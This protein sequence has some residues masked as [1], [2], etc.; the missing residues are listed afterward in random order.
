MF[1]VSTIILARLEENLVLMP[2]PPDTKS[3]LTCGTTLAGR[4]DKK[5]CDDYCR[6]MYNN[7]VYNSNRGASTIR[8]I[9]SILRKNRRILE[10]LLPPEEEGAKVMKQQLKGKG[11]KFSYHTSAYAHANGAVYYFCYE[12]GY[13]VLDNDVYY[14]VRRNEIIR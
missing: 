6:S 1:P 14:V 4:I 12:Y 10:E 9:N 3:C 8:K 7:K 2:L 11:F 13:L 5:F